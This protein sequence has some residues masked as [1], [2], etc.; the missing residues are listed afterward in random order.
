MEQLISSVSRLW[1]L[2]PEEGGC[3]ENERVYHTRITNDVSLPENS[4]GEAEDNE[5]LMVMMMRV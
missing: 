4:K 5:D 2:V 1:S 3:D